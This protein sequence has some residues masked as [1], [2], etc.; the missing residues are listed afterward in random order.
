MTREIIPRNHSIAI[1]LIFGLIAILYMLSA[2]LL[3]GIKI[4]YIT[5]VLLIIALFPWIFPYIKSIEIP[6]KIKI[7]TINSSEIKKSTEKVLSELPEKKEITSESRRAEVEVF[8]QIGESDPNLVIVGLGIEI[9]KRLRTLIERYEIDKKGRGRFSLKFMLRELTVKG[10][11]PKNQVLG[12]EELIN[13][14]NQAAHGYEVESSAADWA[15]TAAPRI[16]SYLDSLI[17]E[18]SI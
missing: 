7:D 17:E 11:I 14:R 16:L 10:I 13:Y 9:E 5:I 8:S 3:P 12:L 2:E 15:I 1:S 6:G 18:S 4:D